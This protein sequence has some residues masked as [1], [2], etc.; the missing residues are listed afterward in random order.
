MIPYLY[1]GIYIY[2]EKLYIHFG[3]EKKY[4]NVKINI[5]LTGN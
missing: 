3:N 4:P 5:I 2:M 1:I